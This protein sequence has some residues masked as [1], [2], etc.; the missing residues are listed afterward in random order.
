VTLTPP[1]LLPHLPP[2]LFDFSSL[3]MVFFRLQR[4]SLRLEDPFP[5]FLRLSLDAYFPGDPTAWESGFLRRD[6]F[7]LWASVRLADET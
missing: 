7:S 2:S 5:I 3:V 1:F 4:W 6:D